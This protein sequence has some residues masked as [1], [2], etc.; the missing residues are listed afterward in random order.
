MH[1]CGRRS[2][3]RYGVVRELRRHRDPRPRAGLTES[4][5]TADLK[6]SRRGVG[7]QAAPQERDH[8]AATAVR[9]QGIASARGSLFARRQWI[10]RSHCR[11]RG[12]IPRPGSSGNTEQGSEER[13]RRSLLMEVPSTVWEV[14]RASR[15]FVKRGGRREMRQLFPG[16][17]FGKADPPR[18]IVEHCHSR[19]FRT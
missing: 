16:L 12:L 14:A 13:S 4:L 9:P 11:R 8:C 1:F 2:R 7:R 17:E 10:V 15:V 6:K 18:P 19:P 5:Q 3:L